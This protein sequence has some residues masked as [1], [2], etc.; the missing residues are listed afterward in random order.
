MTQKAPAETTPWLTTGYPHIWLPYTQMHTA[1]MPEAVVGASGCRIRLADGRELIDGTASWW[2]MCHGYQHPH[3]VEAIQKQAGELSHV[4]FGGLAHEP[5][6]TLATRLCATAGM[7]MERVFFTESGSVAVEVALKMALQYWRNKGDSKRSKF[8]CFNHGYHGDTVGAM[9]VSA[10]SHFNSAYDSLSLRNYTLDIPSDEYSFAEFADTLAAIKNSV[11]ALIIEPLV[12]AAGGFRFHSPD[13]LSEIRR[14]CREHDILFIADE[15]A[16]GFARTG[17]LFA[18]HEAAIAPDILCLGKALSGGHMPLAATLVN[19]RLFEA[20]L[21]DN[22]EKALMHGPTFMAHPIACAAANAS[23]DL[24]ARE[25]RLAQAEA[26]EQKLWDGLRP[27][28][29]R[30][31]VVDVRVKGAIGVIETHGDAE[32]NHHLR[33]ALIA[34]GVWLRPFGNALYLMPP[35]TISDADLEQLFGAIAAVLA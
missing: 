26:L 19:A 17:S 18:C 33:Q 31:G 16:T 23:L 3:I 29:T 6:Y 12:Q 30:D 35:L 27:F 2:S 21:G 15:I 11:A 10:R 22:D 13:I 5:A 20:F 9:S 28:K 14:V 25:P 4:M 32:N 7:G 8:I 1:A 24:F 34:Q